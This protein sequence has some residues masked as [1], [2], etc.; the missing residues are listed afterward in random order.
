MLHHTKDK[1][2]LAVGQVI[3]D[4]LQH[5]IQVCLPIS[6]HLPFDLIAVSPTMRDLRRVQVVY[7]SAKRGAIRVELRRKYADRRGVH[8]RRIALDHVDAFAIFSP[9]TD[10]VYYVRQDEISANLKSCLH[11]RIAASKNGQNK[12]IRTA[13]RFIGAERL[14]GPVAQVDRA[15]DF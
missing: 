8:T 6:E 5:G 11:L 10:R 4:L 7:V 15:G 14:F 3:G 9:Q 13:D 12:K 1:G 2:D